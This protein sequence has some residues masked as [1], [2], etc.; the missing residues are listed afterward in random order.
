MEGG[1]GTERS[2]RE[3]E[4]SKC[5][6]RSGSPTLVEKMGMDSVE[7]MKMEGREWSATREDV[8]GEG[9]KEKMKW[10]ER[11]AKQELSKWFC[12]RSC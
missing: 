9:L 4:S 8:Y 12:W 5:G 7:L 1:K 10:L 2:G 3:T 6:R 11:M